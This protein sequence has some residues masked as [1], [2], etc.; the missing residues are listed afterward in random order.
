VTL[1]GKTK[2]AYPIDSEGLF[3]IPNLLPGTYELTV[4]GFRH[5]AV[6]QNVVVGDEDVNLNVSVHE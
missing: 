4:E 6:R 1:A 5:A 2:A 3:Q